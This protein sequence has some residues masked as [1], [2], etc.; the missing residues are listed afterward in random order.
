MLFGNSSNSK[1]PKKWT[2]MSSEYQQMF[3]FHGCMILLMF[4][5]FLDYQIKILFAAIL[6]ITFTF[7]SISRRRKMG[8]QWKIPSILSMLK[9]LLVIVLAGIFLLGFL[10]WITLKSI[11][12][13][14]PLIL[15]VFGI[16]LF[17]TLQELNLVYFSES[18][19]LKNKNLEL[20]NVVYSNQNWKRL[21]KAIFIFFFLAV[22]LD[23]VASFYYFGKYFN[24]GSPNQTAEFTQP[25]NNH[26][27]V[28]YIRSSEKEL[29]DLLQ[30]IMGL[31]IPA[32]FAFAAL[33]QFGLRIQII[34]NLPVREEK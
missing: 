34:P 25:L 5:P 12:S 28:V 1:Y 29:V 4:L 22:W 32:T 21:L 9:A 26:G 8:W 15:A 7:L 17:F 14:V 13:M 23:G 19:F 3:I 30:L 33:L 6:I 24:N 11:D 27:Q 10:P 16:T 18:D 2:E 20:A 31:G